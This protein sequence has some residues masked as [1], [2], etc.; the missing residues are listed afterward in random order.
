MI[1]RIIAVRPKSLEKRNLKDRREETFLEKRK[2]LDPHLGAKWR[3]VVSVAIRDRHHRGRF[4]R[5]SASSP[6][7]V[8]VVVDDAHPGSHPG[9]VVGAGRARALVTL[10]IGVARYVE[11]DVRHGRRIDRGLLLIVRPT[12][13]RLVRMGGGRGRGLAYGGNRGEYTAT[14]YLVTLGV[15]ASAAGLQQAAPG[16]SAVRGGGQG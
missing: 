7:T 15:T 16:G 5:S 11:H 9:L 4:Q 6:D 12:G 2:S 3:T 10:P 14:A 1:H 8:R 13:L